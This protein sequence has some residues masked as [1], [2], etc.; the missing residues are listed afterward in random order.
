MDQFKSKLGIGVLVVVLAY[1]A[2]IETR[3]FKNLEAQ[4][5]RD[6]DTTQ[7]SAKSQRSAKT[8]HAPARSEVAVSMTDSFV[9]SEIDFQ[10][11]MSRFSSPY[12]KWTNSF[13]GAHH[14]LRQK[15][16]AVDRLRILRELKVAQSKTNDPTKNEKFISLY[17][18]ILKNT[19]ETW[20]VQRQ[21]M[22]NMN[23]LWAQIDPKE[24]NRLASGVDLRARAHWRKT[25]T[26]LAAMIWGLDAP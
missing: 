24:R 13:E 23:P 15:N 12:P 22:K 19:G 18:L 25:D 5:G 21:A 11:L 9:K 2:G 20:L 8:V 1:W 16:E 3:Q 26:E 10:E 14:D 7:L 6:L 4:S 17:S